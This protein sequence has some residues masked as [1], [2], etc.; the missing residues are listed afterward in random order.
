ME[1][2]YYIA[3]GTFA[4][5]GVVIH[6]FFFTFHLTEILIRY[7]TLKNVINSVWYPRDAIALSFLLFI[8]L[9]YVF[10]IAG[11]VFFRN[12]FAME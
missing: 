4:I 12:D 3:F 7:P 6:P 8:I 9:V 10:S 11:H 1:V 5:L 2:L